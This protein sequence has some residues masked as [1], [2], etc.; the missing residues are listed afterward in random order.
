M[1]LSKDDFLLLAQDI[2]ATQRVQTDLFYHSIFEHEQGDNTQHNID[3]RQGV[4]YFT[5]ESKVSFPNS[6]MQSIAFFLDNH[7][8]YAISNGIAGQE[9][10]I[11]PLVF[12]SIFVQNTTSPTLN[13]MFVQLF[14]LKCLAV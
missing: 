5:E 11:P 4:I 14:G 10:S 2:L 3:K 6:D 9:F 7:P 13:F 1:I 8:V 12:D